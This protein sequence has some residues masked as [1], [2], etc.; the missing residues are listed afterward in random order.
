[1]V[2]AIVGERGDQGP[3]SGEE[4]VENCP[5]PPTTALLT[6]LYSPPLTYLFY[7]ELFVP[8][9]V[10]LAFPIP[11]WTQLCPAETSQLQGTAQGH[12]CVCRS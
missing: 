7:L 5:N 2:E 11:L 4:L 3:S 8:V 9:A 6:A 10:S 12:L 1:M